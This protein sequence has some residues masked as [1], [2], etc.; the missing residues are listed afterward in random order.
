MTN[1]RIEELRE[2]KRLISK[3]LDDII[4]KLAS[5]P[6]FLEYIEL[7][8]HFMVIKDSIKQEIK[9]LLEKYFT[10]QIQDPEEDKFD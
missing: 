9:K 5:N 4:Q 10:E 1:K 8:E 3:K 2:Q 7:T 6:D